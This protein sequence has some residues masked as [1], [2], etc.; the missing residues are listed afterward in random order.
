MGKAKLIKELKDYLE[1]VEDCS[2]KEDILQILN[3]QDLPTKIF[4][5]RYTSLVGYVGICPR[6]GADVLLELH[7]TCDV[8]GKELDWY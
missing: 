4:N 7:K 6:C 2:I 8:C 3:N 1:Q 5:K